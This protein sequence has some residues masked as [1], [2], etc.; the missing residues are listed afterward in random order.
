MAKHSLLKGLFA[1]LVGGIAGTYAMSWAQKGWML[2]EE[3]AGEGPSKDTGPDEEPATVEAA[4]D[5]S[6]AVRDRGLTDTEKEAAGQVMHYGM[7][8]TSGAIYGATTAVFPIASI[9]L[10]LPFGAVLFA[11]ADEVIVPALGYSD[12]PGEVAPEVH[13][14]GLVAHLVYG[15]VTDLTRR[16]VL[17]VIDSD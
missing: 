2:L 17:E 6:E 4:D 7:G 10:G 15:L 8:A 1:G 9:G 5:V 11:I 3:Q 13:A 12:P 16:A 14:R